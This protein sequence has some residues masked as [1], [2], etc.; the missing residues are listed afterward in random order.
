MEPKYSWQNR[1]F[2]PEL[3]IGDPFKLAASKQLL[4]QSLSLGFR[5]RL[6]SHM[7]VWSKCCVPMFSGNKFQTLHLIFI[8]DLGPRHFTLNDLM[9]H[10]KDFLEWTW[11]VPL[12]ETWGGGQRKS[13]SK[14]LLSVDSVSQQN[15]QPGT[16][17][18]KG[19]RC[20]GLSL[21]RRNHNCD[22]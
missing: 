15:S 17:S 22:C 12:D 6:K 3:D 19:R 10:W 20:D 7:N 16:C 5:G 21:K 13:S 1:L 18:V 14:D 2:L 9:Q 11:P 4:K 8:M